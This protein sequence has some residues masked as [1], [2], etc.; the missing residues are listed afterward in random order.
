MV[1][2]PMTMF[3][4]IPNKRE[5][6]ARVFG[7]MGMFGLL[8]WAVARRPCLVVLTYHRIAE[9]GTDRFYEPVISATPESFYGQVEWLR[10]HV[11]LLTLPE[12]L[13]RIQTGLPWHETRSTFDLRRWLP[14]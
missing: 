8:E 2:N 3:R 4:S 9:P 13:A 12:L 14:R 10:N 6:L 7:G 5:Y 11:R 1:V